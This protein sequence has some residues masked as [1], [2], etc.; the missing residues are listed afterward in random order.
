MRLI[1]ATREEKRMFEKNFIACDWIKSFFLL[2]P[3]MFECYR[4]IFWHVILCSGRKCCLNLAFFCL[5]M[6]PERNVKRRT[7]GKVSFFFFFIL[8]Y[9]INFTMRQKLVSFQLSGIQVRNKLSI[10]EIIEYKEWVWYCVKLMVRGW[11]V[12]FIWSSSFLT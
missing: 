9:F 4:K 1:R 3:Y 7:A 8:C 11:D 2:H 6:K 12:N 10:E 5:N